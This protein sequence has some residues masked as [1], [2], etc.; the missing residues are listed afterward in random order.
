[1]RLPMW[2]VR[3]ARRK[4]E[5]NH[6]DQGDWGPVF[7]EVDPAIS[8][9]EKH[10]LTEAEVAELKTRFIK[11]MEGHRPLIVFDD[12]TEESSQ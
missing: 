9:P 3:I 8:W 6:P 10:V 2:L 5:Q 4:D 7:D 12:H 11:A 1:M